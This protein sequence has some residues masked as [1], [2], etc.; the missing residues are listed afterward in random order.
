[1][2]VT[3][4]AGVNVQNFS[5]S[6]LAWSAYTGVTSGQPLL[7]AVFGV[8]SAG[9]Q[10]FSA[11]PSDNFSTPYTWTPVKMQTV[12]N[13]ASPAGGIQVW[14]GTGGAGTSGTVSG[15]FVN[16]GAAL[17]VSCVGAATNGGMGAIDV[18]G[19]AYGLSATATQGGLTPTNAGEGAIY[20]AY[21]NSYYDT[22]IPGGWTTTGATSAG[23]TYA[24]I[25]TLG[26]P[27]EG[28]ALSASW[29]WSSSA[30]PWATIGVIVFAAGQGRAQGNFLPLMGASMMRQVRGLWAFPKKLILPDLVVPKLIP[31]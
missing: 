14:I 20:F 10:E 7:L 24:L 19:S 26:S 23:N 9:G 21:N 22:S 12:N 5:A 25:S 28:S 3:F 30:G 8:T 2:A 17:L 29:G 13:I 15:T 16:S 31:A 1:M 18:Y 4:N 6:T 11:G 27:T